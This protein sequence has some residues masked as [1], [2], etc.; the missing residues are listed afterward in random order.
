MALST[1]QSRPL[2]SPQNAPD[3]WE[4]EYYMVAFW[5]VT[6]IGPK[7]AE[8]AA[9]MAMSHVVMEGIKI[10]V[11]TNRVELKPFTKLTMVKRKA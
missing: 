4:D 10:P 7:E 9:N 3:T 5:W 6:P 2:R 8:S 11:L 1:T